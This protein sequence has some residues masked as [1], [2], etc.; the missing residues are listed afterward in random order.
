MSSLFAIRTEPLS[1]TEVVAWVSHPEAGAISVFTGTVR[2]HHR[3]HA[4]SWLEYQAYESMAQREMER[5]GQQIAGE[6]AGVR[7][8]SLHRDGRLENGETD[9]VCAASGAHREE[10][11][12]ACRL[13][14]DGIKQS[15][16]IWKLEHGPD[17][18][19]W[20]GWG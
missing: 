13:L 2:N 20:V 12:R 3:G 18:E 4:V 1:I 7:H 11:F 14:I 9:V 16:P 10:A 8:A 6:I 17:G 15:V 5:I 19:H